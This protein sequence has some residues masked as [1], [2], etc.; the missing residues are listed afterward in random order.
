MGENGLEFDK[1]L[2]KKN[3]L[4]LPIFNISK[5]MAS[6]A[7]GFVECFTCL[8]FINFYFLSSGAKERKNKSF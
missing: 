4:E 2:L 1:S 7:S 5:A 3:I 6:L 8:N